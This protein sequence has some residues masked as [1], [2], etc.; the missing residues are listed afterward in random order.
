MENFGGNYVAKMDSLPRTRFR[1][2][3]PALRLAPTDHVV[4]FGCGSGSL[5]DVIHSRIEHYTGVDFSPDFISY[6]EKR[7]AEAGITNA[8]FECSQIV[9][10]CARHPAEFDIAVSVDMAGYL[11]DAEFERVHAAI[12]GSLNP[13]G[14]LFLYMANGAFWLERLKKRGLAPVSAAPYS[15]VRTAPE[16]LELLR[17]SG[18]GDV[19]VSFTP[20]YNALR[21]LHFLSGLPVVGGTF[22]AKVLVEARR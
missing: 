22:R 14:R 18:F 9:D 19:R 10:F 21:R 16:Y 4:D 11:N 15:S 20:H 5:L 8:R 6:A 1:W 7:V 2:L 3:I 17:Q 13:R 12:R